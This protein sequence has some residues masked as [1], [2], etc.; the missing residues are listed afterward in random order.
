MVYITGDT[1][2]NFSRFS[3]GRFPEMRAMTKADTADGYSVTAMGT[4]Q[5]MKST[6]SCGNRSCG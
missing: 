2:R 3:P 6:C 4:R 1:H 5:L